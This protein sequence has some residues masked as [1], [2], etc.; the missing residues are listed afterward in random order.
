MDP[1]AGAPDGDRPRPGWPVTTPEYLVQVERCLDGSLRTTLYRDGRP[2]RQETVRSLRH[3]RRR[4]YDLLCTAIDT[5]PDPAIHQQPG[6]PG[7]PRN[8]PSGS[9]Q[10]SPVWAPPRSPPTG[11]SDT[12]AR[13]TID[14]T[15]IPANPTT[16]RAQLTRRDRPC[17][18]QRNRRSPPW[19]H[20]PP[21]PSAHSATTWTV[22]P[23]GGHR[24]CTGSTGSN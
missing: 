24:A 12:S 14:P 18:T 1:C 3:G 21:K 5:T 9:P 20:A 16:T 23:G 4:A 2:I 11:P 8:S 17:P 19:P 22:T 7:R 15:V 10:T 6:V 13:D